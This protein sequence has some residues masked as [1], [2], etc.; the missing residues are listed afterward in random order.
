MFQPEP[1]EASRTLGT[2]LWM[3]NNKRI[4]IVEDEAMLSFALAE[5][6]TEDG[7]TV[8]GTAGKLPMALRML[9]MRN[10]DAVVLDANLAGVDAGP[11][12]TALKALGIPF[13]VVSGYFEEQLNAAFAGA[14]SIQK[15]CAPEDVA[16]ALRRLLAQHHSCAPA[17]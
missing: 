2:D 13:V 12:A 17:M 9:E 10:F 4:L 14:L 16:G 5:F 15:P 11:A 7:F 6:L 3:D 8:V 1:R